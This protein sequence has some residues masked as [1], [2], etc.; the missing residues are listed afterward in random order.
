VPPSGSDVPGVV[1]DVAWEG[2]AF[3]LPN[4]AARVIYEFEQYRLDIARRELRRAG[5]LVDVEPQIFDLLQFLIANRERVVT[6]DDL[7]AS[8]WNGRIVSESTLS[9]CITTARQ[10]IG[11][12]GDQQRLVRTFARKG[13]RFIGQ[14]AEKARAVGEDLVRSLSSE[15]GSK[16]ALP[17]KPSIAVLPFDNISGDPE[18]EYFADGI[19]EDLTTALSQF[20]WL[21]VIA[22]GSSFAFKGR[23]T[24][25]KDIAATLGVRYLLEGSVR[26]A[27]NRVRISGQLIDAEAGTN[28]W[29]DKFDGALEDIFEL[30]DRVTTSVVGAIA[31][32]LEQAE[33]ERVKHKPTESLDAYDYYL[34]G[35]TSVRQGT[36]ESNTDALNYFYRAIELDPDFS[37]ALGMAAWCYAWRKW[38]AF[39]EDPMRERA[40]ASR[41]ARRAAEVG[42]DD[43]VGLCSGGYALVFVAHDLDD[44][45]ALIDRALALNSNLA[46]AWHSSGWSR[47]FL[48]EPDLAIKHLDHAMRLSPLDP[49]IFRAQG[50]MAYAHFFADHFDE[51]YSWA[52]KSILEQPNYRPAIRVAA[53]SAA[54][55]GRSDDAD[56]AIRRLRQLDPTLRQSNLSALLPLRR[57]SDAAKFSEGL[58]KAGLQS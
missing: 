57:P 36:K 7:I 20:R 44:G 41:L 12:S 15:A 22:R 25:A 29:A 43:A 48:G 37:S 27:G 34:R 49:L 38:D 8:V 47:V 3:L 14:V 52:Q 11:D 51:A 35:I 2:P 56:K 19:T 40:E 17:S 21:F 26:K 45:V 16:P 1:L 9:S 28:L 54:L 46:M 10:A 42:K 6:K 4:L 39:V 55:A 30:Q 32:K 18:Q 5:E 58:A 31:P 23:A 33:I 24:N 13:I 50:G 53:A